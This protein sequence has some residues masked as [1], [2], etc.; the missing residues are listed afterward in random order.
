[1]KKWQTV[2]TVDLPSDG[3][4]LVRTRRMGQQLVIEQFVDVPPKWIDV[5]DECKAEF[6]KSMSHEG[7]YLLVTYKGRTVMTTGLEK[8]KDSI[9]RKPF[10]VVRPEGC[11]F[12]VRVYKNVTEES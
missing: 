2:Q 9:V 11:T 1:M 8:G 10:K 4:C 12:S 6:R 3:V 5:T 7:R